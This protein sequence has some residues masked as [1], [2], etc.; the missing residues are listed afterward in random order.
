MLHDFRDQKPYGYRSG[1]A[2]NT[3]VCYDLLSYIRSIEAFKYCLAKIEYILKIYTESPHSNPLIVVDLP[4][5]KV[6]RNQQAEVRIEDALKLLNMLLIN[7]SRSLELD[8]HYYWAEVVARACLYST[9]EA[10]F[11]HLDE[12]NEL[13]DTYYKFVKEKVSDFLG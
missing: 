4:K 10:K 11:G 5:Y 8:G 12:I 1:L 2:A 6:K 3:P 7:M 13:M 9:E